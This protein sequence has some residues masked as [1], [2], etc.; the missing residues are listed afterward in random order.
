MVESLD[1]EFFE[2]AHLRVMHRN[3]PTPMLYEKIV[4][5]REGQIAHLGPVV[6]RTG[7]YS[8]IAAEDKYIVKDSH[9]EKIITWSPEKNALSENHFNILFHR[10]LAYMHAQDAYAQDCLIGSVAEYRI[11]IRI[12]TE[13]A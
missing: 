12:I 2:R 1:L 9:S 4:N 10:M 8:P 5:N 7:H 6:V 13:T 11:P 3:L